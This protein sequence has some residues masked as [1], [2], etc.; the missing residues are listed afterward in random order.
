MIFLL[1]CEFVRY[2]YNNKISYLRRVHNAVMCLWG[3]DS[4]SVQRVNPLSGPPPP[5]P[6]SKCAK[7]GT[8]L[9]RQDGFSQRAL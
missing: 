1:F 6:L 9:C 2:S 8:G 4:L 3:G 7:Q 5:P